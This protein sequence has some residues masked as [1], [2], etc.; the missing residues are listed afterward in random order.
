MR[1]VHVTDLPHRA[2]S[3]HIHWDKPSGARQPLVPA[4]W[5]VPS[6]RVPVFRVDWCVAP[7]GRVVIDAVQHV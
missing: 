7:F 4:G 2:Y 6:W 5:C 1:F 3:R